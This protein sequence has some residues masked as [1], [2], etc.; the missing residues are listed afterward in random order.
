MLTGAYRNVDRN[1]SIPTF[2]QQ[3]FPVW[4]LCGLS[5]HR[6]SQPPSEHGCSYSQVTLNSSLKKADMSGVSWVFSLSLIS[7]SIWACSQ[8]SELDWF[9]KIFVIQ[10][11]PFCLWMAAEACVLLSDLHWRPFSMPRPLIMESTVMFIFSG[12]RKRLPLP[13]LFNAPLSWAQAQSL[14]FVWRRG[15]DGA[16]GKKHNFFQTSICPKYHQ[17]PVNGGSRQ[18][19]KTSIM[20]EISAAFSVLKWMNYHFS[21]HCRFCCGDRFPWQ[22]MIASRK[23]D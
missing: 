10:W 4:D 17:Q 3:I 20:Q 21:D 5:S 9:T 14:A 13:L 8:S 23:D 11:S 19:R 15:R 12:K 1:P 7:S 18:I 16:E 22:E 2:A 6:A